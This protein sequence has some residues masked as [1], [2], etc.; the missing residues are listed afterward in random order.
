MR[1]TAVLQ[2]TMTNNTQVRVASL[3]SITVILKQQLGHYNIMQKLFL[4][5][6]WAQLRTLI[7]IRLTQLFFRGT[8]PPKKLHS[9]V[10]RIY[11]LCSCFQYTDHF[12]HKGPTCCWLWKICYVNLS[13][14]NKSESRVRHGQIES[15]NIV[16]PWKPCYGFSHP[17]GYQWWQWWA[18][19]LTW[20]WTPTKHREKQWAN[21]LFHKVCGS[22]C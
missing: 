16:S 7:V 13:R 17:S 21:G 15:I 22:K 18:T 5:K 20:C 3:N 8:L 9:D 10:P 19:A 4:P 11:I 12:V 1:T 2:T 6:T 14:Y